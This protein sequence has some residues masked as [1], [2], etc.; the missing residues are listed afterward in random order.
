MSIPQA[1]IP[2]MLVPHYEPTRW[3][4]IPVNLDYEKFIIT[5]ADQ[6]LMHLIILHIVLWSV[7]VLSIYGPPHS[8]GRPPVVHDQPSCSVSIPII[9]RDQVV[10]GVAHCKHT[11]K[12][13]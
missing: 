7:V 12:R 10:S 4:S 1:V 5:V 9:I 6:P 11:V 2:C 13:R 8:H 3:N